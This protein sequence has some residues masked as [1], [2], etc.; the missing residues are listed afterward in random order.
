MLDKGAPTASSTVWTPYAVT[1][2]FKGCWVS[3]SQRLLRTAFLPCSPL[4]FKTE[5]LIKKAGVQAGSPTPHTQHG[6]KIN[7]ILIRCCC[8][9]H[10]LPQ[11]PSERQPSTA[12]DCFSAPKFLSEFL[13][14]PAPAYLIVTSPLVLDTRSNGFVA[15]QFPVPFRSWWILMSS[16]LNLFSKELRFV[17]SSTFLLMILAPC[18][19]P[20]AS[21]QPYSV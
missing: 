15:S 9:L 17:I 18:V 19:I 8:L 4:W 10:S 14:S 13:G 2:H 7:W 1:D 11:T 3:E 5:I 21:D 16:L 20:L 12:L 6:R